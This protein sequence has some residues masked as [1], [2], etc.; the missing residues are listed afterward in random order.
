MEVWDFEEAEQTLFV[1]NPWCTQQIITG[2]NC[3]LIKTKMEKLVC[4]LKKNLK[5]E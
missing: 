5:R 3:V 1:L 4:Y 2:R